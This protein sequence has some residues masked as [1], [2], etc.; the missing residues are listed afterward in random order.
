MLY[1]AY[2]SNM[3]VDQMRFRCPRAEYVGTSTLKGWRLMFK[4]SKS[5][6][7]ATI[8]RDPECEVPVVLWDIKQIDEYYLDRYEGYP[9]FY[10]KTE[11][12]LPG[13]GRGMVYIMHED[14]ALGLPTKTYYGVLENAYRRFR[15][16]RRILREAMKYSRA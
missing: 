3:D 9:T 7:Y 4:G 15:F 8:E 5:G 13:R 2:G 6:N 14:R 12:D 1:I 10:Y 11:L 16:P